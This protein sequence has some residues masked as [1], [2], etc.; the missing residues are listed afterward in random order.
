MQKVFDEIRALN[1]KL[2]YKRE[3][4]YPYAFDTAPIKDEVVLPLCV[5]FPK[6]TKDVQNIVKLAKK[7]GLNV[8]PRGAA[9][10]HTSGCKPNNKSIVIHLSFMDKII[11]LNK[12]DLTIKVEPY[13]TIKFLQNEAEKLGLFFPPDPSNLAV[14]TAG[15]AVSL[16]SGGPRAFKYGTTKDYVINL[17]V[18]L[19]SGEIL[20]T[21]AYVAKNVTGYNL[22]QLFTGSE[23]TLGIITEITFRLIPKPDKRLVTLCYF[24]SIIKAGHGVNNIINALIV[25]ATLDLLDR[26]TLKTIEKFNP[27]G[28]FEEQ[29]AALLIEIDGSEAKIKEDNEKLFSIL[30][31][32]GAIK[33]IQ[34]KNEEENENIWKTRRS[35]YACVTKLRPNAATEDVVVNRSKI[36]P[37]IEGIQKLSLK[38][39]ITTCI[40]GHAGDGNIHPN[41]ALDLNNKEEKENFEK[42]KDELFRLAIS[43]NGSLSGE[44]G[45]GSEKKPY[46]DIAL[47]PVALK[48]MEKI[49]KLF[50]PDNIMNPNKMF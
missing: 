39:N 8:I 30:E 25:P 6:N 10:C 7:Y 24:D 44:H 49:K 2:L 43:L 3:D 42:L 28:L 27:T 4:V 36:V 22:T 18:V 46:L 15:G 17:K 37:L 11:E 23:G 35:A 38:Y 50:D 29:E 33:I 34:S 40:M 20:E 47:E 41:F 13:V 5:V 9:T 21:G 48:Y 31:K 32:S 19:A 12:E 45:I 1:I 14:S 16:S 26:N